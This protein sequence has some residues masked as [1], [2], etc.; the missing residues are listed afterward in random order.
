MGEG[1]G[2]R[3]EGGKTHFF[4]LLDTQSSVHYHSPFLPPLL[5][6]PSPPPSSQEQLLDTVPHSL[7]SD[8]LRHLLQITSLLAEV[9][10]EPWAAANRMTPRTLGMACGL[11]LFPQL[12]PGGRASSEEEKS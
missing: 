3:G 10:K 5:P 12:K 4:L 2:V 1:R 8:E 9:C 6:P 11:S 7:S